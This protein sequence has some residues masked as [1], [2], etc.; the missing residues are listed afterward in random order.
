MLSQAQYWQRHNKHA[1]VHECS[2]D[3][4][5][6]I[7]VTATSGCGR[8]PVFVEG[9][10]FGPGAVIKPCDA[11]NTAAARRRRAHRDR[12]GYQFVRPRLRD[13]NAALEHRHPAR[14]PARAP[15]RRHG[16]DRRLRRFSPRSW[17]SRQP[18]GMLRCRRRQAWRR[19]ST[20]LCRRCGRAGR[21]AVPASLSAT[22]ADRQVIVRNLAIRNW[23]MRHPGWRRVGCDGRE[24]PS[25]EQRRLWHR[26]HRHGQGQDR[27]EHGPRHRLQ[28]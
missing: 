3:R 27:S 24:L 10:C 23:T 26:V 17:P 9:N 22:S 18:T 5:P 19:S 1:E 7:C 6:A 16:D 14:L 25:G 2:K 8:H 12:R 11:R 13:I 20:P 15:I 4:D 28:E 21:E